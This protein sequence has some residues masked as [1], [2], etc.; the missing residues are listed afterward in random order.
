M[1]KNIFDELEFIIRRADFETAGQII[2]DLKKQYDS[3]SD[4]YG[5]ICYYELLTHYKAT[6]I[7]MLKN[8]FVSRG[9][10]SCELCNAVLRYS[11]SDRQKK[12]HSLFI[13][14]GKIRG[15]SDYASLGESYLKEKD[16]IKAIENFKVAG[17]NERVVQIVLNCA[18]AALKKNNFSEAIQYLNYALSD[19]KCYEEYKKVKNYEQVFGEFQ[20]EIGAPQKYA[21][22]V[23][24]E[25]DSDKYNAYMK[26]SNSSGGYTEGVLHFIAVLIALSV[27][28]FMFFDPDLDLPA[29]Y[30]IWG[31]CASVALHRKYMWDFGIIKSIGG[32]FLLCAAP[33]IITAFA[34]EVLDANG[35][36]ALITTIVTLIEFI[37]TLIRNIKY[38][39]KSGAN[40]KA[41]ALR[42]GFVEP[43]LKKA[44]RQIIEK[45]SA[46][47]DVQ[48]AT[49]WA[50]R[51]KL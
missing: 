9:M 51:I 28:V 25:A 19:D 45:Y 2:E 50:N 1:S 10:P 8:Y 7:F 3:G 16:Y 32:T 46:L 15:I 6:D 34:Y 43:T 4:E 17:E 47:T 41:A 36:G 20:K 21:A 33:A 24:K 40:K 12:V 48:T 39:K 26:L 31:V 37:P 23:L 29:L 44:R 27:S 42:T 18:G 38:M 30:V 5:E 13:R 22:K 49:S 14:A 35:L 11:N